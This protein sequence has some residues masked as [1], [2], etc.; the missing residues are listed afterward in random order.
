M[1]PVT[2]RLDHYRTQFEAAA[3][4][5]P[6]ASLP[7][8]QQTRRDAFERFAAIGFPGPRQE[9]WKYTRV[10]P[11][12]KRA[13]RPM[14]KTCVGLAPEDLE[15]F[16]FSQATD[17]RLTFINGQHSRP[18]SQTKSLPEGV[19]VRSLAD[20]L[21]E[22]TEGLAPHL[23]RYAD[24]DA[25]GFTAL[26]TAFMAD[27][28]YV[29]VP[30][31]TVLE[32]PIHLLFVTTTQEEE[33]F[34]HPRILIVAEEGAQASVI[35]SYVHLGSSVYFTNA[36]TEAVVGQNASIDHYKVQ[37]EHPKAFH[38]ATLQVHQERDSQFTSH[39]ASL[40]GLLVRN[41]INTALA[42]EGAHCT[43]NG[44]YMVGGRQ[45]V[46]Y[47]TSIHHLKPHCTSRECYKGVLSGRARGVFNGR[48][49]VHPHAQ[50]SDAEQAND[51]LLLSQDAEID[52][53]PQLEIY[54]DDVKC[55]HGATVGQLDERMV[56]YL[57]SRGIDQDVARGLLTYGFA[58]D[59]VDRMDI[60]P[61]RTHMRD[62]LLTQLPN[63]AQI[64][65]LVS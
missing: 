65:G 37:R 50:K 35:E 62:L 1:N 19:I 32:H 7:W 59:I 17:H 11:I 8:L 60:A 23:A 52:T 57:R 10:A 30:R 18:L 33:L 22:R 12:E 56:F 36:L 46:D 42:A 58:G 27:G 64:T 44:L 28:A 31:N 21:S 24:P 41:D 49:Y 55:A 5:M 20:A 38:I 2:A 53:K 3:P 43:L 51:N 29:H 6:G 48:I 25:H 63:A 15:T 61:V 39:S 34:T 26:N 47:H 14:P 13:F 16:Y 45:H 4:Q 54:A 40:G 9:D